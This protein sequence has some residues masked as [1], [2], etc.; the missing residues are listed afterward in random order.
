VATLAAPGLRYEAELA[1][2]EVLEVLEVLEVSDEREVS[3]VP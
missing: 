1:A 3:D 2:A